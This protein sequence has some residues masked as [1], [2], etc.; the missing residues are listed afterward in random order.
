MGAGLA[1]SSV[2]GAGSSIGGAISQSNALSVQG[3]YAKQQS[4]FN[5][6]LAELQAQDAIIRGEKNVK[7]LKTK[8]NQLKGSQR[9][10][11]AAAGVEVDTGSAAEL[12][13]DT[14]RQSTLDVIELRNNAWRE[15]WGFKMQASNYR[16]SGILEEMAYKNA[17]R[18][19]L[20]TG[21][22]QGLQY[23]SQG[24]YYANQAGMFEPSYWDNLYGKTGG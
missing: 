6:Q 18:N 24:A 10:A 16:S 17:A 9:A 12:Q 2:I 11:A 19:T 20:I 22:L 4:D 15:A 7:T 14:V 8:A 13:A 1:I 23:A 3:K 21:G 5:A